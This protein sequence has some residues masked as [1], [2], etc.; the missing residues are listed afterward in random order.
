[1]HENDVLFVDLLFKI[2]KCYVG[3]VLIKS[4]SNNI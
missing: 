2:T 3:T 1:M 4:K